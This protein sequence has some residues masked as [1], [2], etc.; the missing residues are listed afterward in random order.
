MHDVCNYDTYFIQKCDAACVLGLLL[1]QKLTASLQIL[2]YG[3]VVRRV[4][5]IA[6]MGKSI[7]LKS[8][9]R[10]YEAIKTLYMRD[11]L[12]KPTTR[13]L[14]RLLQKVEAR[15]FPGMIVSIDCMHW[16]WKN[17]LTA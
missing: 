8:L 11:Y 17:C 4:D 13:D 3:V 12:S 6:R 15:G 9:V 10:F 7:I 1:E 5:E 14:Q 16:Q 2:A